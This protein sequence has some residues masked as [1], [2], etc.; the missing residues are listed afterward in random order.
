MNIQ[1]GSGGHG[2]AGGGGGCGNDQSQ[3]P[4]PQRCP[5]CDSVNTK[6]CYYNNYSLSQPSCHLCCHVSSFSTID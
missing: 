3:P 6:F 2:G 5:Q 1:E 4:S